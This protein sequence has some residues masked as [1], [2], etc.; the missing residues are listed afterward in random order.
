MRLVRRAAHP[1]GR[2]SV[3]TID[4]RDRL[5][6][7]RLDAGLSQTDLARRIGVSVTTV[8]TVE[9][10]A[11]DLTAPKLFAW[12]RACGAALDWV[13]GEPVRVPPTVSDISLFDEEAVTV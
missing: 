5:R 9:R 1:L 6:R 3:S 13:A 11:R 2:G 7:A 4:Y 12:V 8:S 10:G